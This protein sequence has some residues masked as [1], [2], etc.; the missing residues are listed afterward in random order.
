MSDSWVILVNMDGGGDWDHGAFMATTPLS[1][2][3]A[4]RL[5]H[6]VIAL[7]TLRGAIVGGTGVALGHPGL[8]PLAPDDAR[9]IAEELGYPVLEGGIIDTVDRALATLLQISALLAAIPVVKDPRRAE[10]R[11]AK[12]EAL[13]PT[14]HELIATLPAGEL[15]EVLTAL[16]AHVDAEVSGTN[17]GSLAAG[18]ADTLRTGTV[19][20]DAVLSR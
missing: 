19:T 15:H 7:P 17:S 10:E 5:A 16:A 8:F 9:G 13:V 12:A 14:A 11:Q 20:S 2:D 4:L 3:D 6:R 1:D 18:L